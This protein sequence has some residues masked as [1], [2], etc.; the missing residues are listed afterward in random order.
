M[1]YENKNF[2]KKNIYIRN[3]KIAA[4]SPD[5]L[6]AEE[7]IDASSLF[8]IPGL[9][10]PHVHFSMDAGFTRSTDDFASGTIAAAHGGITT[11]IDFL[12]EAAVASE[13]SHYFNKRLQEAAD[14]AIDFSF[15]AS[16]RELEDDPDRIACAALELGCPTIKLYTTYREAGVYSSPETI[17]GMVERSSR[18]DILILAHCE[19][20]G[21]LN[22]REAAI[23]KHG[24]NRPPESEA[25]AVRFLASLARELSGKAYVVHTSCG[26]TI[27]MLLSEFN[28]ILGSSLFLEGAPHYF[29]FND[30]VYQSSRAELFTMTPPLRPARE[31]NALIE[32]QAHIDCFG[33]DHCPFLRQEKRH[34]S[35]QDIPMG[36]SGIEHTFTALYPLLGDSLIDRMTS[37]AARIHG[38]YPQKGTIRAGSD[39]DLVLFEKKQPYLS[40]ANHSAC[41]YSIYDGVKKNVEISSVLVRG[42]Y[43]IRDKVPVPHKGQFIRRHF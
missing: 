24:A 27:R 23:D 38:L 17:R 1:I 28:E 32:L 3:G 21:M 39:A 19:Q 2:H 29:L 12:G 11:V 16:I 4:I 6:P 20:D 33:S 5:Y 37:N 8:V 42:N 34:E 15:H 41:D 36:V 25:E 31:Q 30:S 10:D 18:R 26:S 40:S 13:I 35:I 22:H 9:I 14:A 43:V 7:V